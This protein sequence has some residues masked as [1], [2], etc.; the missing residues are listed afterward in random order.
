[1]RLLR[2]LLSHLVGRPLLLVLG[3]R[4]L[5][6]TVVP[7]LFLTTFLPRP[8][9]VGGVDQLLLA[10]MP[11]PLPVRHLLVLPHLALLHLL[12]LLGRPLERFHDSTL[13]ALQ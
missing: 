9:E 7:S 12:A 1:M 6:L 5:F 10:Q 2:P 11:Q 3:E 8:L 13:L 4:G